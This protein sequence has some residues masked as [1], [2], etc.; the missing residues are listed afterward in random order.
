MLAI[1][2]RY[3]DRSLVTQNEGLH[4]PELPRCEPLLQHE[5]DN[6]ADWFSYVSLE[7]AVWLLRISLPSPCMEVLQH[8]PL[9]FYIGASVTGME[10]FDMS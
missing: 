2:C 3:Q 9:F 7:N 6:P 4:P 8:V 1:L 10:Q 5:F